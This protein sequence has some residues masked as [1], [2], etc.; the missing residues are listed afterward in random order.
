M[1]NK[2]SF[3]KKGRTEHHIAL[4]TKREIAPKKWK[5]MQHKYLVLMELHAVLALCQMQITMQKYVEHRNEVVHRVSQIDKRDS[6]ISI[7]KKIFEIV[8][9][10]T[11]SSTLF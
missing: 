5:T 3:E 10:T 9:T 11:S 4:T 1:K 6:N 8:C 7:L 2:D